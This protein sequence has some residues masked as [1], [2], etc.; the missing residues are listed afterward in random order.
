MH[1]RLDKGKR[2]AVEAMIERLTFDPVKHQYFYGGNRIPGVSEVL[3][4]AGLID[5]AG[6]EQDVLD[7]KADLGKAVHEACEKYDRGT[8]DESGLTAMVRNYFYAYKLFRKQSDF[9]PRLIEQPLLIT[10]EGMHCGGTLDREGTL[11]GCPVILDIKCTAEIK[12]MSVGPQLSAYAI[13]AKQLPEPPKEPYKRVALQLKP[14]Q[15]FMVHIF[16]DPMD[17]GAFIAGLYL[18]WYRHKKKTKMRRD[19]ELATAPAQEQKEQ[20]TMEEPC[21][22]QSTL[23][24]ASL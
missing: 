16:E 12:P 15:S 4:G 9:A 5:Y 13:G 3:Q 1:E 6:I 18:A 20:L 23:F 14:D 19:K 7:R 24:P 11:A 21:T 10:V 22:T 17:R 2:W 8:L